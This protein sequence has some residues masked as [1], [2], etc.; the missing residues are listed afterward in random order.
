M[1]L[2]QVAGTIRFLHRWHILYRDLKP[3][4]VG[5]N[6]NGTLKLFNFGITKQLLEG[7]PGHARSG[8]GGRQERSTRVRSSS[9]N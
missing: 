4:N 9:E 8:G 5:F 7:G 1:V 6:R 2:V 3:E